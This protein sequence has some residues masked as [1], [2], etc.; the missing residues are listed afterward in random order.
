MKTQ[1]IKALTD[2]EWLL[3]RG[4]NIIGSLQP[5]KQQSFLYDPNNKKF[6][7][8][9]YEYT[10]GLIKI[11]NEILDNSIDVA[12]KS[13]FEY[14]NEISVEITGTKIIITDNGF[15]I[16]VE[17]TSE[18][19]WIPE[20]AWNQP[21]TGSNFENDEDR[22][23]AGMNG[24]GSYSTNVFSKKFTGVTDDGKNRLIVK[25]KDNAEICSTELQPSK[26]HGTMVSF[27]PDLDRFG[28]ETIDNLHISLIYQ[29]I[30][31]LSVMYPDIKFKFN[32][33]I[34]KLDAKKF[35]GMFSDD[36]E[37]IEEDNYLIGVFSNEAADF[38]Y[39]TYVNS[40]WL[41]KG[42]NHISFLIGKIVDDL[43]NKLVRKYKS[44]KPGD[45]KNKI[46]TVVFFRNFPNAKFDGQTKEFLTNTQKEITGFLNFLD[47]NNKKDWERFTTK[48]YK[49]KAIIDPITDL[50]N[51]KM[52]IEEKKKLKNATKKQDA[53]EKYWP[54]TKGNRYL[55]LS[56]GDSAIGAI[57]AELDREYN[58]FFPLKGVPLNS[59]KDRSKVATNAEIKQIA[60]ILNID[61]STNTNIDLSYE[62]IVIASDRDVDGSHIAGI[63]LGFFLAYSPAYLNNGKIFLFITPLVTALDKKGQYKFLFTM[64]EYED[65]R[66]KY[67]PKG[68]KF[69]YDYKKGLGSLEEAE[70]SELFKQYTLEKL[71]QPLHLKD[72][73]DPK[74]EINEL[75]NWLADNAD[76]R[77]EKIL[78]RIKDFDINAV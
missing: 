12:I 34:V 65:F 74:E 58:G 40:L 61:L 31:N 19:R 76:F 4:H 49:N 67:D 2:R 3:L 7:W 68:N 13:N 64:E 45:I 72:S 35:L 22:V 51:A 48:L 71:L 78:E 17:K 28:M 8:T 23:S 15:G 10:P 11:I 56:E 44:M 6:N 20:M 50:Y 62:N 43:R 32:K 42:G 53:P 69:I 75:I 47:P 36:F 25:C 66:K 26:G 63:L 33:R 5:I 57:T 46:S 54:A 59:I 37:F 14:A 38:S 9:T 18:G 1:S 16:P 52:L 21:R 55:F 24:I 39:H 77:K 29:R 60:S 73:P 27:F 70:W 30:L 41:E